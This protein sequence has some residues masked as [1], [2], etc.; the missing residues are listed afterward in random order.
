[1][2]L[3]GHSTMTARKEVP[4]PTSVLEVSRR[5]IALRKAFLGFTEADARCLK[6]LQ[7]AFTAQRSA[8]IDA[9][10]ERLLAFPPTRDL[11]REYADLD[12]LKSAQARYFET[13]TSGDYGAGYVAERLRVGEAHQRA[14]LEPKWYLGT[15]AHYLATALP[16]L[17]KNSC[18]DAERFDKACAALVK[19]VF[20]DINLALDTYIHADRQQILTLKHY[21]ETI[22]DNVADGVLV[23]SETGDIESFNQAAERL[24]G[25]RAAEM[26]GRNV[27]HLMSEPDR[28]QHDAYLARYRT[29]GQAR[30]MG[31]GVREVAGIAKDGRVLTL[32]LTISEMSQQGRRRYIGVL[33]DIGERKR[34]EQERLT[35]SRAIEQSDDTVVITDPEGVIEYVNPSFERVTGFSFAEVKGKSPKVLK[36]GRHGAA[37]YRELWQT[38]KAGRAFRGTFI[39]RRKDGALYYEEKT[40][41]PIKDAAGRVTHFVST[42]KDITRRLEAEEQL[43]Y[44]AHHDPVTGLAN[45]A[46]FTDRLEQAIAAQQKNETLLAVLCLDLDRFKV[47]NDT[48]GPQL[49]DRLLAA[50]GERLQRAVPEGTTVARW[51]GDEF[52]V[53]LDSLRGV[54]DCA[55]TARRILDALAAPFALDARELFLT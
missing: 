9:L 41:T 19:I 33:R 21:A 29:T 52:T 2:S 40:I 32:E 20:F 6:A 50:V 25:Y 38:V 55:L 28:S 13:L 36:S 17:W 16:V 15:Y 30:C 1:M 54:D 42:G 12:R 4:G 22:V 10:Y 51:G 26:L 5:E 11:L 34:A 53:M 37:F 49:G 23:I 8:F 3:K 44:L 31:L 24:F 35:L 47:V 43:H 14:G 46:L 48:L 27:R 45:R 39:N 18:G 7:G